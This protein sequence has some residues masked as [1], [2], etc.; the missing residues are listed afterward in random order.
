MTEYGEKYEEICGK[1]EEIYG[2]YKEIM[3]KVRRNMWDLLYF[4]S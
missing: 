3:R 2:K 1:Y 4:S